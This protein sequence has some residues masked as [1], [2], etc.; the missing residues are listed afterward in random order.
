MDQSAKGNFQTKVIVHTRKQL[1]DSSNDG[2]IVVDKQ[3][4]DLVIAKR[5][6]PKTDVT[7]GKHVGCP[8]QQDHQYG[9][10]YKNEV[11]QSEVR[12]VQEVRSGESD[13][14]C[15]ENVSRTDEKP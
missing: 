8:D 15:R 2:H 5:I 13:G 14:I 12:L 11:L 4:L 10:S 7:K 9:H 1:S 3:R 6:L